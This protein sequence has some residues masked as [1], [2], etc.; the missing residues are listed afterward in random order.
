MRVL[1]S[2]SSV[3]LKQQSDFTCLAIRHEGGNHLSTMLAIDSKIAVAYQQ[4]TVR[5]IAQQ[6]RCDIDPTIE[7]GDQGARID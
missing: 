7:E 4:R 1:A 2:F 6:R 3:A 5:K